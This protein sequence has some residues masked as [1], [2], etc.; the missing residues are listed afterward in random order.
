VYGRRILEKKEKNFSSNPLKSLS[1]GQFS[2]IP[3][4]LMNKMARLSVN[5]PQKDA[6]TSKYHFSKHNQS[7]QQAFQCTPSTS[8]L[9][10]HTT[11]SH[12]IQVSEEQTT[13]KRKLVTSPADKNVQES[14]T[15]M[16]IE[17]AGLGNKANQ[18][19]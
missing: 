6:P 4:G 7:N 5:Q 10:T 18:S 19:A 17:M 14:Q 9:V 2:P 16:A 11:G 1:G 3:K 8:T 12:I 13:S 15:S